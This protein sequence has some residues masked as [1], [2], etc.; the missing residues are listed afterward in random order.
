MIGAF[1]YG[2]ASA[3]LN[4]LWLPF[5]QIAAAVGAGAASGAAVGFAL[6]GGDLD[7]TWRG[8]K[9]G[10]ISGLI[11][12]GINAY[13]S[14]AWNFQRVV[15]K[16]VGSGL[17]AELTGGSF[18]EGLKSGL[19]VSLLTYSNYLMRQAAIKQSSIKDYNINGKSKGFFGDGKKVAGARQTIN[20]RTGEFIPCISR[21]GGC[22]GA[23]G[24]HPGDVQ[25]QF[26]FNDTVYDPG[27]LADTVNES[28][29]GPHDFLRNL[30]G[31]YDKYGNSVHREG[32]AAI[33]DGVKNYALIPPSSPF[34][35]AG[36]IST[37]PYFEQAFTNR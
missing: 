11:F 14:R 30:T 20:K 34:A 2:V 32:F 7:A 4:G 36:L 17:N 25:S 12:G 23:P 29:A 5:G 22:Q 21:A 1:T 35:A 18:K 9:T 8:A 3:F 28:F 31:A 13:Y 33:W 6:S 27:S 37:D 24:L 26:F 16:G 10:A 15:A 19:T